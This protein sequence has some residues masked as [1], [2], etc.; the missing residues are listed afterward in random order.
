M[1]AIIMSSPRHR[2]LIIGRME[3][4][5]RGRLLRTV[6][7]EGVD[8]VRDLGGIP[9]AGGRTVKRG[10]F[11]RGGALVR[12]TER[13]A[14]ELF[15][16]LGIACII[17]VRCGWERAEKPDIEAPGV[18]NLHIP[19]YD[20]EKVGIEYTESVAGTKTIGR[21]VACEPGHFYRS[22]ANLLTVNQMRKGLEAAFS[23]AAEGHPVYLH[24]SG[25]KD[26][27]GILSLLVLTVLGADEDAILED[28][29]MTNI[30]RDK[31]YDKMFARF[32]RFAEGDKALA[33]ELTEAHR[34][35]PEN[36]IAFYEAIAEH[37]GSMEAFV[38]NQL[39][40]TDEQIALVRE[41]CTEA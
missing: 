4:T 3:E 2:L 6:E 9:V 33:R 22:L 37:Y 1:G 29:L 35:R 30:S 36:I 13:D 12:A 7:L 27:V 16:H 28:Y 25:G 5:G 39:A 41:R 20:L 21:D 26:R 10:L 15:G 19:F 24:C 40:M 18:E 14:E 8:N 11:F 31:N 34:A 38:H 17:D 32:L 23:H